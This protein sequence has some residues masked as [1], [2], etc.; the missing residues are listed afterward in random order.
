MKKYDKILDFEDQN[1]SETENEVFMVEQNTDL[2]H[3]LKAPI[4]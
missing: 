1:E 4:E 3:K 2:I